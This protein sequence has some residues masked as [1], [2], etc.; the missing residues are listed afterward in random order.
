MPPSQAVTRLMTATLPWRC[1]DLPSGIR[2]SQGRTVTVQEVPSLKDIGRRIL[3][4]G[5][6][7]EYAGRADL[8]ARRQLHRGPITLPV[9]ATKAEHWWSG[10]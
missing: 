7:H 3:R 1:L 6:H 5:L 4:T 8:T 2:P 10:G 9:A